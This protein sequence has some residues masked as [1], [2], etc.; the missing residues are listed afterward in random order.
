MEKPTFIRR[1]GRKSSCFRT[2]ACPDIFEL[3]NG[4]FAIIGED[5]TGDRAMLP[6][7]AGCGAGE[8]IVRI[9]RSLLI[10]AKRDI[11]SA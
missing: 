1:L 7:D 6:S 11:P 8:R 3:S 9:P 10:G 2:E 5:I 4:D